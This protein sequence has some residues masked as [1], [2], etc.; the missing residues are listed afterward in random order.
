MRKLQVSLADFRRLCI[1]KGVYPRQPSNKK[2]AKQNKT[3]YYAKDI[4]YILHDPILETIRDQKIWKKKL[5]KAE[6]K[7]NTTQ[8]KILLESKPQLSLGHVIKERYP[9]FMD[10]I[11]D[12]DDALC[13]VFLFANMPSDSTYVYCFAYFRTC[14][15]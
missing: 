9:T 13:L 14:Y 11:R 10:A 2:L 3:W 6:A 12:L 5:V 1:I 4:S 7:K 8:V 15:A